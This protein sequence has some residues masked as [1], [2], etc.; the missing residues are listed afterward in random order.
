MQA[1]Y[2]IIEQVNPRPV[3]VPIILVGSPSDQVKVPR[4]HHWVLGTIHGFF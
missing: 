4:Y 2:A 1:R 3:N